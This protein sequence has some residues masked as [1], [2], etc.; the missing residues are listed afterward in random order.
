[1]RAALPCQQRIAAVA[2]VILVEDFIA[3]RENE[4]SLLH[5]R[6]SLG[7]RFDIDAVLRVAGRSRGGA[8]EIIAVPNFGRIFADE[9]AAGSALDAAGVIAVRDRGVRAAR[10]LARDAAD[11]GRAGNGAGI[12][13]VQDCLL[14]T[15]RPSVDTKVH[16]YPTLTF[17][18][19]ES[20]LQA[21]GFR[22]TLP[23]EDLEPLRQQMQDVYKRQARLRIP[24]R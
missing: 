8:F 13:A 11:A 9:R 5:L 12:V 10:V 3:E 18:L 4:G 19:N 20:S 24:V 17:Q 15:S 21:E 6:G 1:M 2:A 14:Y 23:A 16:L 22:L 7:R